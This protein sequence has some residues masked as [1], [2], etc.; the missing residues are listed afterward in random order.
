MSLTLE[1]KEVETL[2]FGASLFAPVSAEEVFE[3][4]RDV[5]G[6]PVWAPGVRR[7]EVFGDEL[8]S[9]TVSEWEVS[10]LG[11]T[12]T[13]SSVLEVCDAPGLLR[14]EYTS[15]LRGWGRCAVRPGAGGTVA[16]FSTEILVEDPRLRRLA[17]RLPVYGIAGSYMRRAL[18]GLGQTVCGEDATFFVGP[19]E[20]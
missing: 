9:G 19:L 8:E 3:V 6:F 13:V 10:V 20:T 18:Q 5:R 12:K 17:R 2:R 7:V 11:I 1:R 16:E 4:V 14:W 15:P